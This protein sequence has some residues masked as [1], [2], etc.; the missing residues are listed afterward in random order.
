MNVYEYL[1]REAKCIT[2]NSLSD[3]GD[4]SYWDGTEAERR[5]LFI[6]M[7]GLRGH[8]DKERARA[9]PVVTGTLNRRGYSIERTYFQSLPGLYVTGN[10]YVPE[11]VKLAPGV[12]YLC[13]HSSDQKCHYQAHARKF[14]NLGFVT[15]LIET[16]ERGEVRGHHHGP[17][18]YGWFNWYSL[19]YTPAGVEVWN[20][21]NAI[22]VLQSRPEVDP[23]RIG[24]TGISGGGAISW[25]IAAVDRR[26]KIAA[27]VCGTA[28]V[29]SH[30]CKHTAEEHCDCMFWINS[31]MWDLTDVGALIA[32]R[33][34]L[35][36]SAQRDWMFDIESVRLTYRKLKN[37]YGVLGSPDN[38]LLVETPGG[39]SYH[40]SSRA[41]IFKWFLKHLEG[42]DASLEDIGDIDET[43]SAQEL[44]DTLRVFDEVPLDERVTSVQEFFIKR[45]EAPRIDDADG[46][47][48]Y[49]RLLNEALLRETFG[50]FPGVKCDLDTDIE[51]TQEDGA[52][53]GFLIGFSPEEG[54]R[55]RMHV[56]R[57]SNAPKS[58]PILITPARSARAICF[59]DELMQGL[60]GSWARASVEV[61]GIGETSWAQDFQ[62]FMRRASMLTGR[63]VAS[64]RVYDLL[65]ALEVIN[66]L[67][68]IDHRKVAL[69]GS[70]DMAAIVLYAALLGGSPSIVVLHDPPASQDMR[71]DIVGTG[72]ALEMLNC[73][74]HTDLPYVA[75]LLWPTELVFLGPRPETYSWANSLYAKLGSPGELRYIK[76]LS[77]LN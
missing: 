48:R 70:G 9:K 47:A 37:L 61:R 12:L 5:R 69:M 45:P 54:L 1:R 67:E 58:I 62:W 40:G 56:T 2:A 53:S 22:D 63:T 52:S 6:S 11:G 74:R 27:P 51:L 30:V 38:I 18:H 57:P 75:G 17:F 65:R 76:S 60:S 14:A 43:P 41:M 25:F 42:K 35:I 32:P 31:C 72:P 19:G 10:L 64:M 71:S 36:C 3:L 20:A 49:R 7:L 15:L 55:L 50:A 59:G 4:K 46:I 44:S 66:S 28:T 23:D 26:V 24:V 13:G 33:P 39:H 8:L 29:E 16:I 68:W 73:L 77:E 34:L 21:V